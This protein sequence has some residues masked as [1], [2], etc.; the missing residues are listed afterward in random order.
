MSRQAMTDDGA[1]PLADRK[2]IDAVCDRFEAAWRAGGRPDLAAFLTLDPGPARDR[3]F[4]ELLAMELEYDPVGADR[5]DAQGYRDRFP[6]YHAII[7]AAFTLAG[8]DGPTV[9]PAP[10]R[11][12]TRHGAEPYRSGAEG[13]TAD[14]LRAAGYEVLGELGR[15]GMGVVYRARQVALNRTVALKVIR[16]A[17]FASEG[18]R[19]RFQNEAEA[20]A[21][22]DHPNI[23]PVYEVGRSRGLHFFSMK[24]VAGSSLEK[25]LADYADDP[26]ASARLVAVAAGAI[27]HAHSRGILHRDL[28]P[29]NVLVDDRGEPHVTD[30]GLA[31]Q[32][33]ADSN[34]TYSGALVG[35]PSFMSPEQTN[36]ERG[37]VTTATDV[38]G[39]GSVLYALLTGRAPHTGSSLYETIEMVR[40]RPPEPPSRLN[41]R[42]PR[43]LEVICLKCLEKDPARRYPSAQALA[44][45]LT[46]WLAGEPIAARP[47]GPATRAWM[48][49]RRHP[50]PAALAAL[51]ALALVGGLA[52]V[53][54]MWQA[55]E[56]ERAKT[57]IVSD[58]W[59]QKVLAGASTDL[60]PRG[61]DFTVR[62]LLD[63]ATAR[64]AGDFGD[65]PGVE[66]EIR[67]T[68]GR[69]YLSLG[70]T[71]AAET[72]LR[73]AIALDIRVYGPGHR[74][75]LHVT[76]LL[77]GLLDRA[78]RSAEAEPLARGNLEACRRALGPDDPTT[79]DASNTLGV[80]LWHRR[81]PGEAE[82]LLRQTLDARRRVL[83]TDHPDTLRSVRN[84]G[85][86][87]QDRGQ[88]AEAERLANEYEHGIRCAR[89]PNHPD[90]VLALANLGLLMRN[91]GRPG[92]SERFYS[93]A[94]E[95]ARRILGPGHPSALDADNDHAR[96]LWDAGRADDAELAFRENLATR[97]R[98]EG[99]GSRGAN[100][101]RIDLGALLRE[102]RRFEEAE[103]LLRDGSEAARR[104]GGPD[105]DETLR[106]L[107]QLALLLLE[108]GRAVESAPLLRQVLESKGRVWG[109]D[110][111][112]TREARRLLDRALR[113][114]GRLAEGPD[115]SRL[116]ATFPADPFTR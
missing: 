81:K 75:T 116:D 19:R 37:G 29:A 96:A 5:P 114:P 11:G 40:V 25:R 31:R 6:E 45:D 111:P 66:A 87:L 51:L 44:D 53:T 94:S 77:A 71:A 22:F 54:W 85:L 17:G 79:L 113:P 41:G 15:G 90:N 30:F 91:Q 109:P 16:S 14:A 110:H 46:R 36:G 18:E 115:L 39:L 73:A 74:K 57:S 65:Q 4:R 52:G 13:D 28:K 112:V 3:L 12:A 92:E 32:V 56:G 88:L 93:R 105:D 27:Q 20:V 64:L 108:T 49:C 38:Y 26:R 100:R 78:G 95:E 80:V 102:R 69:A 98:V 104:A 59:T 82:P 106:A 43:D 61:A 35:T 7:D 2:R 1:L 58:F 62:E 21:R 101:A 47:V 50:L 99:P 67:E 63:L 8:S 83:I 70:D 107:T 42:V 48:W 89:G 76:D 34:L 86:F 68:A 24:L 72:H 33:E 60:H 103:P 9:I 97:A 23:V 55:A 10:D 84:L